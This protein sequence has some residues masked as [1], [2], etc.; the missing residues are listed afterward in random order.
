MFHSHHIFRLRILIAL[1]CL[2]LPMAHSQAAAASVTAV[3]D[4]SETTVGQPVQLQIKVSGSASAKPPAEMAADGLDIRFTGQSQLLEGRNFQF[5]YSYIYNY[6]VMPLKAGTFKIPPQTVQAGGSSYRTPELTLHVSDS[7]AQSPRSN[8]SGETIDPNKIA[9]VEL[10]LSKTNAYVGEM[11][12][13]V[14]R[15]GFNVRTPVESLG[16]GV[17]ITGQGFTA[18]KMREPRQAIETIAGKTYQTFT[19]KTALSPARSGKIEVGPVQ[20]NPVVRIPRTSR[21]PAFPR[22]LFDSNDPFMDNFFR[23]PSFAPS[24]PREIKLQSEAATLEVKAL[25]PGAPPTFGGAVGNFT[26]TTEVKPKSA[27]V[28]DPFTVTAKISGRG[29]FD[30]VTAPSFEDEHGWHKYPPSS[31]FKPDDDIGI[32][33]AKTFETVL[34]ANERKENIP[35]QLFTYF[36][37]QKEQYVT[38]RNEP[39]PVRIEGG[40]AATPA[41]AA[42]ATQAP[43]S[44]ASAAPSPKQQEIL[45]QL[46]ELPAATESFT[47]LFA[48]RGFWLAQLAPLLLLLGFVAWKIQRARLDDRDAR[49]REQLQHEAAALQR[50]LRH[51]DVSPQEY[52]SRAS[53]AVQLKTALVRNVEPNA[54]D[55]EIAAAAFRADED[56]RRR[57][58]E[59]FQKSDEARYSGGHNGIRLLPPEVRSEVLELIENLRA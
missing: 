35:A 29:N 9:F 43:A 11:I 10:I 7:A 1:T 8:R 4:N 47:P 23:D 46:T 16:N 40:S 15:I 44:A 39:I 26:M 2:L 12:P 24:T 30:R 14:V 50:S 13:A 17:E 34:S 56:T 57:L 49:R 59:L 42:P 41:P 33:G 28:G 53:R 38:L 27:Q 55:A 20:V 22:D 45:H 32:S 25:P 18:Q 21:N 54:V 6:T 58:R 48:R 52:F 5:T 51:E 37:P 3:L 19:F 31:D 36:D